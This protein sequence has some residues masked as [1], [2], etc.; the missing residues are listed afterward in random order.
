MTNSNF[1][2][3]ILDIKQP[4]TNNPTRYSSVIL[5]LKSGRKLFGCDINTGV[6]RM[7]EFYSENFQEGTYHSFQLSGLINY[8]I[9]LE[10]IGSIFM[11][12]TC[13]ISEGSHG[14]KAGLTYFSS[15]TDNEKINAI[16]SLRN[17]L[18]HRFGLATEKNPRLKPPRKF[19]LSIERNSGIVK[20]PR[21]DWDGTFSNRQKRT[22]TTIFI[23][24]LV[25]LI[26]S[27]YQKI[28]DENK[29]YWHE[30]KV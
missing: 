18:V 21:T 8:L 23:I 30:A 5:L 6:Y 26:E 1:I 29:R 4:M 9:F 28:C 15:M 10:Q 19:I 3:K 20:L 22:S 7:K 17:S 13:G 27:V 11:P 24:D 12:K 25:M 16:I 2:S 14:I